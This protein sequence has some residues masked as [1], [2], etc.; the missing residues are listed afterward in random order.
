MGDLTYTA[1]NGDDKATLTVAATEVPNT[2]KVT[3][4]SGRLSHDVVGEWEAQFFGRDKTT[5]VPTGVAGAF[6]A[7]IDA[8]AVVVGG[9][10]ATK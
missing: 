6:N 8:Q 3:A 5:N 1:A 10:G 4:K 9:F 7:T 2:A